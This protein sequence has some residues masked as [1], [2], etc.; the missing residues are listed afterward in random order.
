MGP[1][2]VPGPWPP[3]VNTWHKYQSAILGGNS[4]PDGTKDVMLCL[5]VTGM[6]VLG[7]ESYAIQPYRHGSGG[8]RAIANARATEGQ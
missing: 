7:D 2:I 8:A 6:S 5:V 3:A 4:R 1:Y